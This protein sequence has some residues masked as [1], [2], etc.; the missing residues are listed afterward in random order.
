MAGVRESVV[1]HIANRFG[2]ERFH[3]YTGHPWLK[4]TT[5]KVCQH[6]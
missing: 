1:R 4:R 3:I 2:Y 6:A 5:Q